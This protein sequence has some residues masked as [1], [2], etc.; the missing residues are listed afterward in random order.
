MADILTDSL[1]DTVKDT[2]TLVPFLFVTYLAMEWIEQ[3]TEE[4]SV[5]LLSS[6]GRYGHLL[7]AGL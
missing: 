1:I 6:I 3:R 5:R 2:A 4:H 7:G